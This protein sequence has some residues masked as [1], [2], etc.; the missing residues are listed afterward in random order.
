L[1]H[2]AVNVQQYGAGHRN[3]AAADRCKGCRRV[4]RPTCCS[5]SGSFSVGAQLILWIALGLIFAPLADPLLAP[6][7]KTQADKADQLIA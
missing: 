7:L 6:L 4:S 5:S 3:S 2:L 1:G